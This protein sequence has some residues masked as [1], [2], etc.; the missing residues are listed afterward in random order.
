MYENAK[1]F[2]L[3]DFFSAMNPV[4][5]KNTYKWFGSAVFKK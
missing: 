5:L 1:K 3:K 2:A 4:N